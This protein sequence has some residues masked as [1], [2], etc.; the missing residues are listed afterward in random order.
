MHQNEAK[1]I[2]SMNE[3]FTNVSQ[4][5]D[6]A[7]AMCEYHNDLM[8]LHWWHFGEAQVEMASENAR[9]HDIANKLDFQVKTLK[10]IAH[11]FHAVADDD[12]FIGLSH[13]ADKVDD[14][15]R[16]FVD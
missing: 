7:K 11:M 6:K 1:L 15:I 13:D 4:Q 9:L 5:L 16:H 3:I 8:S 14:V 10:R 12:R 2:E